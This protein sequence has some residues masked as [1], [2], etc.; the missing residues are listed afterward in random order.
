M[1]DKTTIH[2]LIAGIALYFTIGM[3]YIIKQ[4]KNKTNTNYRGISNPRSEPIGGEAAEFN[5]DSNLLTEQIADT[6]KR[7]R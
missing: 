1:S 5:A 2:I 4:E 6:N 7:L 3:I